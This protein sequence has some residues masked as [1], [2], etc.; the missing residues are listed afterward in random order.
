MQ[1][2]RERAKSVPTIKHVPVF[3]CGMPS[4]KSVKKKG[5]T[6]AR[7]LPTTTAASRAKEEEKKAKATAS[8]L[9]E[10]LS[11]LRVPKDLVLEVAA[12]EEQLAKTSKELVEARGELAHL[13]AHGYK[14][15]TVDQI[16]EFVKEVPGPERV[17]EVIVK[18]PQPASRRPVKVKTGKLSAEMDPVEGCML[19][20]EEL[21]KS[22]RDAQRLQEQNIRLRNENRGVHKRKP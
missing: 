6:R 13:G 18:Q 21:T 10:R 7:G 17:K 3:A 15:V 19:L 20:E 4:V 8:S 2:I 5:G 9:Q 12:L 16:R 14:V 22:R 1:V 11:K